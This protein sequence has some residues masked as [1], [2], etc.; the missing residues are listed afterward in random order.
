MK[1]ILIIAVL[2]FGFIALNAQDYVKKSK[3]EDLGTW[4]R[5]TS[6]AN[7]ISISSYVTKQLN[8]M[9]IN[10]TTI[11]KQ[12]NV[13][14]KYRYELVLQSNSKYNGQAVKTWIS[15]AKIFIDSLE[16]T[17]EQSPNGFAVII[18]TT[19]TVVYRYD[20]DLDTIN[21][22]ITW[23]SSLYYRDK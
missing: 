21:I 16:I 7:K 22:K 13:L 15:G 4:D 17:R 1:K 19:P 23:K 18:G 20:S 10:Q 9:S 2:L 11:Q 8:V 3:V 14:P 6:Q 12:V 5:E